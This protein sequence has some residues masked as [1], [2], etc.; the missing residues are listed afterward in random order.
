MFQLLIVILVVI[1]LKYFDLIIEIENHAFNL[2]T[3]LQ[4]Y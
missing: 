1:V 2:N 3:V 4:T